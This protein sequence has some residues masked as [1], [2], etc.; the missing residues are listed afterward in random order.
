MTDYPPPTRGHSGLAVAVVVAA[1]VF[2]TPL[3]GTLI[4]LWVVL[5]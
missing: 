4:T 5:S 2:G 1:A 3:L